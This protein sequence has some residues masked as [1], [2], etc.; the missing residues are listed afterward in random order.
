M[1]GSVA[2]RTP[3]IGKLHPGIACRTSPLAARPALAHPTGMMAETLTHRPGLFLLFFYWKDPPSGDPEERRERDAAFDSWARAVETR[4]ELVV[5]ERVLSD[6]PEV[7]LAGPEGRE[8]APA[9]RPAAPAGLDRV[10]VVR[11]RD[12]AGAMDLARHA[13]HLEGGGLVAIHDLHDDR[14]A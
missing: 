4:G 10:C 3:D 5:S 9:E 2:R 13:P 14:P 6:V 8:L 11:A 7:W 1:P 12:R